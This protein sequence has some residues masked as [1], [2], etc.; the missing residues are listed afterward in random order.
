MMYVKITNGA[1]S[2]YPYSIDDFRNDNPNMSIPATLDDAYLAEWGIYTVADTPEPA[3]NKAT[4]RLIWGTPT[5]INGQWVHTWE[6]VLL[7]EEEQQN[8]TASQENSVR[9]Q[10]NL[11]LSETDWTQVLDAPV[12]RNVWA[13][14]RQSLRDITAQAGFPWSITWPSKPE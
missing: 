12:D 1:P 7:S 10:R 11:L 4:H 8:M 9:Y 2:K 5:L 14:Y 3:Y 6:S 13:V